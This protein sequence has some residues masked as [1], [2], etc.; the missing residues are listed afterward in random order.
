MFPTGTIVELNTGEVGIV[1]EQNA[2]RRLRPQVMLVLDP[3]RKPLAER[4]VLDLAGYSSDQRDANARWIVSGHDAGA[5]GLD[6][7]NYFIG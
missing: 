3:A 1:V 4:R 7:N 2:E 6:P 5:F